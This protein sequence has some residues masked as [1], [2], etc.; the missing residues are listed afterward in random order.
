MF[1]QKELFSKALI[2]EK[3]LFIQVV[4]FESQ[5]GKLDIWIDF[6]ARCEFFQRIKSEVSQAI[7]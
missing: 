7:L 6:E 4:I 2:V 5:D 3:P 1:S